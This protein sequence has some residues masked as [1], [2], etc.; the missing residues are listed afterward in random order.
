ME[1]LGPLPYD[2]GALVQG[3]GALFSTPITPQALGLRFE[4]AASVDLGCPPACETIQGAWAA[5]P[6]GT[7][8]RHEVEAYSCLVRFPF[9]ITRFC[10]DARGPGIPTGAFDKGGWS[11]TL[12]VF[13]QPLL[14]S[15]GSGGF[16]PISTR[17]IIVFCGGR[18]GGG[19]PLQNERLPFG[20]LRCHNWA[21]VRLLTAASD[22]VGS[23][24]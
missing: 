24:L 20:D 15:H 10:P 3:A 2:S 13:A 16:T 18:A 21:S 19:P 14:Q 22:P 17:D 5:S 4:M 7:G 23:R 8:L 9:R 11:A 12:A 1:P 6:T